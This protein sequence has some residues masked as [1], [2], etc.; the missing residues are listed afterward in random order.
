MVLLVLPQVVVA[1]RAVTPCSQ[2]GCLNLSPPICLIL[3]SLSFKW[4]FSK[5]K[6][7]TKIAY[8]M[9]KQY[10]LFLYNIFFYVKLN[11]RDTHNIILFDTH[12]DGFH[13]YTTHQTVNPSTR[14]VL[15]SKYS[16][17][18]MSSIVSSLPLFHFTR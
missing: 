3:F 7:N 8:F 13:P 4:L 2:I 16:T 15:C 18:C 5:K 11:L 14:D 1:R 17:H 9:S 12:F 6:I 10:L